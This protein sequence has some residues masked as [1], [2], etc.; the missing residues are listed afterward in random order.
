MQRFAII[1]LSGSLLTALL[2]GCALY[3]AVQVAGAAFTGYDAYTLAEEHIPRN[4]VGNGQMPHPAMDEVLQRRLRERLIIKGQS[5]VS[6]HV[7]NSQAYLIGRFPNRT[8]ADKAV[9]I[10]ATVQ[11]LTVIHCKFYPTPAPKQSKRDTRTLASIKKRLHSIEALKSAPLHVDVISGNA[12]LVGKAW[13]WDQRNAAISAVRKTRG[14]GN[15]VDY[16][17]VSGKSGTGVDTEA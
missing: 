11:G 1:I 5:T 6:A 9:K 4:S 8:E 17:V 15:V 14:V 10:T 16:I 12:V 7:I 3:P 13:T 2:T